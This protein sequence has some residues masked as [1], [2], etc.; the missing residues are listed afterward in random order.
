MIKY[1]LLGIIQGI[2]EFLP[3]SSS[4][5]LVVAQQLMSINA[6]GITLEVIVHFATV[7]AVIIFLRREL[8]VLFRFKGSWRGWVLTYVIVGTIP[9][10]IL[11]LL[12][13]GKIE[14]QFEHISGVRVFFI[15]NSVILALSLIKRPHR[16]LNM[17]TA[18]LIGIAQCLALLPGISRSGT[19]I[20]AGLL[21]GLSPIDAFTF[22]FFLLL[23]AVGGALILDLIR[24]MPGF[25][26]HDITAFLF[27]LVFGIIALWVL[28]RTVIAKKLHLFGIYTL[29]VGIILF[30]L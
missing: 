30:F 12:F 18:I 4:G 16:G 2:T 6:P 15:I 19:T 24:G 3:V 21:L 1:A 17:R 23:P 14:S 22:S 26:L 10:V 20:T 9:A 25:V 5:H 13:K 29:I 27:A 8:I 28:K 7:I 11:G